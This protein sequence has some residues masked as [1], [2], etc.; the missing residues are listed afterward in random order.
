MGTNVEVKKG[1]KDNNANLIK[2]F[3]R[4]VQESGVITR[5]KKNRYAERAMSAYVKKTKRLKSINR[6]EEIEEQIKLG[7]RVART[8]RK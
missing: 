2:K 6:K 4:K 3:T 7:K 8:P 5:V 1:K